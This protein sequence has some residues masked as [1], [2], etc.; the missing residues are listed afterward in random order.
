MGFNKPF[1]LFGGSGAP[2]GGLGDYLG[3]GFTV[4]EVDALRLAA[5]PAW[6]QVV[7]LADEGPTIVQSSDGAGA[8]KAAEPTG[9]ETPKRG[10]RAG[11]DEAGGAGEQK[12]GQ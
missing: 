3:A 9:G 6:W 2:K 10:K 4:D 7:V 12:F 1:L 8:P 11:A 5:A